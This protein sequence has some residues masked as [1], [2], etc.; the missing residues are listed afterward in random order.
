MHS[1]VRF[2]VHFGADGSFAPTVLKDST[3]DSTKT[4]G[5]D[6]IMYSSTTFFFE[7]FHR[8]YLLAQI[9]PQNYTINWLNKLQNME[10]SFSGN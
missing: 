2:E 6:N 4:L 8:S 1:E 9:V 3:M 5:A 7:T 10:N